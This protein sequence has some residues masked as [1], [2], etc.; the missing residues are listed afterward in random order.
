MFPSRFPHAPRL[1]D[2]SNGESPR[3]ARGGRR[4]A[5]DRG[6][7]SAAK[8]GGSA[9]DSGGAGVVTRVG[10]FVMYYFHNIL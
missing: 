6:G 9:E 3:G 8:S 7:G 10:R 5:G 2:G 4:R 1:A